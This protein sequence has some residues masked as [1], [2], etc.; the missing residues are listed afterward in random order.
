[1]SA[2]RHGSTRAANRGFRY[3]SDNVTRRATAS[4][5]WDYQRRRSQPSGGANKSSSATQGRS[6]YH[7]FGSG[8]AASSTGSS[9]MFEQFA[10]RERKKEAATA[11]RMNDAGKSPTDKGGYANRDEYEAQ[12]S[13]PLI[14]FAQV[15]SV[16]YIIFYLGTKFASNR[17][18][19][20]TLAR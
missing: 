2:S 11:A 14:R 12:S 17:E 7:E 1:M 19:K 13:G 15:T 10:H 16:C 5:A 4:Y 20:R 8:S 3:A 9:S 18:P 6:Q